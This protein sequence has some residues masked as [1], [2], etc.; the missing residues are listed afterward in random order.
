MASAM[1]TV[2][3]GLVVGAV[4][5]VAVLVG[6]IGYARR[7][8]KEFLPDLAKKLGVDITQETDNFTYSQSLKGKT[9]FT[10][11]ASKELQHKNGVI[12]L[13]DVGIILYGSTGTRADRIHGQEFEY[14]QKNGILRAVGEALI[15][16]GPPGDAAASDEAHMIHV[17][18]SGLVFHQAEG[19]AETPEGITFQAHGL[20]GEAV[21]ASYNSKTNVLILQ[22]AV[23]VS[24]LR[25]AAGKERPMLLTA[26][27]AEMDRAQNT[28][29][30][31]GPEYVSASDAG[32]QTAS[33]ARATVHT[34]VEGKPK[35][36]E[37][38][39]HVQLAGEGRGTIFAERLD[40]TLNDE[41]QPRD[42]HLYGGV[43]FVNEGNK[44]GARQEQGHAQDVKVAFD[45]EGRARHALMTGA[46]QLDEA[47]GLSTRRL[48]AEQVDLALSGGGKEKLVLRGAVASG[49]DGA[50]LRLIDNKP[51]TGQTATGV[52]ADTLT[53]RFGAAGLTGL[54][55][56]GKTFVERDAYDLKGQVRAK[57]TSTGDT[58]A[59]DLKQAEK[60]RME[61]SRAVQRGG[62][63]IVREA[64]AK[65]AGAAPEVEHAR[66]AEGEYDAGKDTLVLTGGAQVSDAASAVYADRVE[67]D[68]ATGDAEAD[69][70]VRVSYVQGKPGS[71]PVHVLALRAVAHKATGVTEFTAAAGA[72]VRMWQGGSQVEA[73]VLDLDR[74]KK[75]V[76]AHGSGEADAVHTLLVSEPAKPGAKQQPPVRVLS[77]R[78]MYTD[79]LR[80]VDFGGQVQVTQ[81][82]GTLHAQDAIVFLSP[83]VKDGASPTDPTGDLFKGKVEVVLAT[84]AVELE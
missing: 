48:N 31:D 37:A 29:L 66:A 60:G 34:S 12:T 84:G 11:H 46:V 2:R 23:K 62:V 6:Y 24:G 72:K 44:T 77:E 82:T 40:M 35:D 61:L 80:Q 27:H 71:E 10:I 30:L 67:L 78:M 69:G 32:A 18:A 64:A 50:R 43:R 22:S 47:A 19:T 45:G 3:V 53:G 13:H 83:A 17:K 52:R 70:A 74:T 42:G 75:T 68:R 76:V 7:K 59:I 9:V 81:L 28:L 15:D 25:G 57:E 14:D 26:A 20:V 4:L 49:G 39:G 1:R 36:V 33:A 51:G 63:E 8:A 38:R 58:L 73:P 21:G 5:L 16:L 79:A 65:K 41:G 55:G 56:V 54:D